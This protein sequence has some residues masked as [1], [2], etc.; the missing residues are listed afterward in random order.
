MISMM[1]PINRKRVFPIEF[2]QCV[3][4]CEKIEDPMMKMMTKMAKMNELVSGMCADI[5]KKN[6]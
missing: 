4:E 3:E 6:G 1:T 2:P 5:M